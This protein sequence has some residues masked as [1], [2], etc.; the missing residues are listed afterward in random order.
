[1][2]CQSSGSPTSSPLVIAVWPCRFMM[3]LG[4]MLGAPITARDFITKNLIPVT[5]GNTIS[6]AIFVAMSFGFSY[7]TP[8]KM[9]RKL[10]EDRVWSAVR[11]KTVFKADEGKSTL[12]V[13]GVT[14]AEDGGVFSD[15][16]CHIGRQP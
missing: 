2:A 14:S 6:G 4:I 8:E 5:L 16:S 1:M 7:G 15:D 9:F 3:P 12:P 13:A 10:V 11:S